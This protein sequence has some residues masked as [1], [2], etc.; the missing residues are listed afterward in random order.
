MHKIILFGNE[1]QSCYCFLL[2]DA[3]YVGSAGCVEHFNAC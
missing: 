3:T 2:C 1:E